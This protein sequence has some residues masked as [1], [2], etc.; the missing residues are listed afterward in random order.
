VVGLTPLCS[1]CRKDGDSRSGALLGLLLGPFVLAAKLHLASLAPSQE[2]QSTRL[3]LLIGPL[4]PFLCYGAHL[5]DRPLRPVCLRAFWLRSVGLAHTDVAYY[6]FYLWLSLACGVCAI[7]Y[8]AL[9]HHSAA[10]LA[11]LG[12]ACALPYLIAPFLSG[13]RSRVTPLALSVGVF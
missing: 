8:G 11:A 4:L 13:T 7:V 1:L 5:G 2:P 6:Q 10:L 9:V 3:F 12:T